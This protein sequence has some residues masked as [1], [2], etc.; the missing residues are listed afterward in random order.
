MVTHSIGDRTQKTKLERIGDRAASHPNTV[1]N[2]LGHVVDIDLLRESYQN[3]DGKRAVG[4][5]LVTKAA[6]G[7]D[8]ENNL[9]SLLNR[10]RRN[11]YK[12]QTSRM[13]E[14][15]KED[16]STRPL[17]ISC[18]EDKIVQQTVSSILTRVYEPLF[19]SC[20]YGYRPG[21]SGHDALRALMKYSNENADG[22]TVE[23]DLRKYFNSIPHAALMEILKQKITDKRFLKLTETLI[24]SPILEDG[25]GAPNTRGCPQG[26]IISPILSNIY[27]HYVIDDWFHTISKT[28]I[29]GKASM[30][31]FA[32]D[33][34]FVFQHKAEA[35]RFYEVLP[36]RLTKFGLTLHEDKSSIIES[37]RRAAQRANERKERLQTYKFLGFQCCWGLSRVGFWRLKYKSR[38]DRLTAKLNGLKAYLNKSLHHKT[39]HV[40]SKV[41]QI[42]Q[43]WINYHAISDNQRQ[44]GGF[45]YQSRRIL[46]KWINRKGGK[47]KMNWKTFTRILEKI[48]YPHGYK[49]TSMFL[50]ALKRATSP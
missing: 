31:R 7:V 16:G 18:F 4:I 9:Q 45:I 3:L 14:I 34:V 38:S 27:L 40:L 5:D 42:V 33:M 12:P 2:N 1:F 39:E 25:I 26:S 44:V 36:K 24:R 19:L 15:P 17:A 8:L 32:D 11:V 23:I 13:V 48:K 10:I 50:P 43:G 49:T 20:S 41:K 29:V 28:H 22:A 37:G 30:V 47:R 21:K 46:M 6:Y 35:E